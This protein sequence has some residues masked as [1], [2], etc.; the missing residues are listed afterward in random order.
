[1]LAV[2]LRPLYSA[3]RG[4][5]QETHQT[6]IEEKEEEHFTV[7]CAVYKK[8]TNSTRVRKDVSVYSHVVATSPKKWLHVAEKWGVC[9]KNS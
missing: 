9:I 3:L 6:V 2:I 7:V 8:R 1:M 4:V 5:R